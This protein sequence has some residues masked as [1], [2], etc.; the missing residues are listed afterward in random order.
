MNNQFEF[1]KT[2]KQQ[3]I[4]KYSNIQN[5]NGQIN[6]FVLSAT[7]DDVVFG[8]VENALE[9]FDIM[10]KTQQQKEYELICLE[11]TTDIINVINETIVNSHDTLKLLLD[12]FNKKLIKNNSNQLIVNF[13]IQLKHIHEII[14]KIKEQQNE[15][16]ETIFDE[17]IF[18]ISGTDVFLRQSFLEYLLTSKKLTENHFELL[19]KMIEL[20]HKDLNNL[21]LNNQKLL[22]EE[23]LLFNQKYD[24]I[25]NELLNSL[26]I[27]KNIEKQNN[28]L[29][30]N[31]QGARQLEQE[32]TDWL[33][34]RNRQVAVGLRQLFFKHIQEI[35]GYIDSNWILKDP[36]PRMPNTS[37]VTT[38]LINSG[39]QAI[40]TQINR[41]DTLKTILHNNIIGE[42]NKLSPIGPRL[43][44]DLGPHPG[45]NNSTYLTSQ[46]FKTRTISLTTT[47]FTFRDRYLAYTYNAN[48][49]APGAVWPKLG[50]DE[51]DLSKKYHVWP[52]QS[53]GNSW[54]QDNEETLFEKIQRTDSN[55]SELNRRWNSW[56]RIGNMNP[57]W[58]VVPWINFSTLMGGA[59][60]RNYEKP[61]YAFSFD[62]DKRA[63]RR[64]KHPKFY[65]WW[66]NMAGYINFAANS[67]SWREL[68]RAINN[69]HKGNFN[70]N[71]RDWGT[72]EDWGDATKAGIIKGLTVPFGRRQ[73]TD[74][75]WF[76]EVI[77][78]EA[79]HYAE[80]NNQLR[81]LQKVGVENTIATYNQV[82][83]KSILY[84]G[85]QSST[86]NWGLN[87]TNNSLSAQ[88]RGL[89]RESYL[90]DMNDSLTKNGG[91]NILHQNLVF[92]DPRVRKLILNFNNEIF[93]GNRRTAM[94]VDAK[95]QKDIHLPGKRGIKREEKKEENKERTGG[96][97][98]IYLLLNSFPDFFK[99]MFDVYIVSY[100]DNR[101]NFDKGPKTRNTLQEVY[102]VRTAALSIPQ[103]VGT[104]FESRFLGASIKR[105]ASKVQIEH[106]SSLNVWLDQNLDMLRDNGF[107]SGLFQTATQEELASIKTHLSITDDQVNKYILNLFSGMNRVHFNPTAVRGTNLKRDLIVKIYDTKDK[108]P[109]RIQ[110][111][112]ISGSE[113]KVFET[114]LTTKPH[115]VFEDVKFLG[116]GTIPIDMTSANRLSA[117][118]P[119]IY[120]RMYKVDNLTTAN[121][122]A[123]QQIWNLF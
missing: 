76:G 93:T 23:M 27:E 4:E 29:Q 63:E 84:S 95:S 66:D 35:K 36:R 53:L 20:L 50:A 59:V 54:E 105:V 55:L 73:P 123:T 98:S 48:M 6:F 31:F 101:M 37:F 71:E 10:K 115:Y 8:N 110:T 122:T 26:I 100:N 119:F 67:V 33:S 112:D 58:S 5:I 107:F 108:L 120:K 81:D 44:H 89:V 46:Q 74:S 78:R 90:T 77:L 14:L 75:P 15:H 62:E 28:I 72:G 109:N 41:A 40:N 96:P 38:H 116:G 104:A 17:P 13:E 121:M 64:Q 24:L 47:N 1:L 91:S 117:E 97:N 49:T 99:N 92:F 32:L 25:L 88:L 83:N 3:E 9:M 30:I 106:K 60:Q 19:E 21:S 87:Y 11:N 79:L 51:H 85:V 114:T 34:L 42:I 118:F 113:N 12:D 86:T 102:A 103:T 22:T 70:R 68:I 61:V 56:F 43:P 7:T 39:N 65:S 69:F 80:L 94:H 45:L 52:W 18:N 57:F 16:I 111:I 82:T 2:L